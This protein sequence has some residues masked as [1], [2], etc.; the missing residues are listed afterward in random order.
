VHELPQR[1]SAVAPALD[2]VA[3]AASIDGLN[4]LVLWR[5]VA[6]A[7]GLSAVVVLFVVDRFRARSLSTMSVPEPEIVESSGE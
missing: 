5:T 3:R 7:I 4:A 2:H 6:G 1:Y